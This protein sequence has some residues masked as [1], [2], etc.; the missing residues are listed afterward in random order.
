[1]L[2]GALAM[3]QP[4]GADEIARGQALA[5]RLCAV[6]HMNPGQGEKTGP[7]GIPGFGAVARRPGQAPEQIVKW[8]RSRP[9][10]MPDHGVTLDEAHALAAYIV[11]LRAAK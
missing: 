10:Q 8:L 1:M 11:S 6:C 4:A 2:V 3:V 9:S 5:Q 7:D